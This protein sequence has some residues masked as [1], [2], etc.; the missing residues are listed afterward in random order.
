MP[1]SAWASGLGPKIP[2]SICFNALTQKHLQVTDSCRVLTSCH[3]C[4]T[5]LA[6][7]VGRRKSEIDGHQKPKRKLPTS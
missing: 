7:A 3:M 5:S 6:V 1:N 2:V 4:S